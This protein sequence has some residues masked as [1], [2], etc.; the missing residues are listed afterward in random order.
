MIRKRLEYSETL[1]DERYP[2]QD[3]LP[4]D[5]LEPEVVLQTCLQHPI[6]FVIFDL[7]NAILSC[8]DFDAPYLSIH[9]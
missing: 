2:R 4:F 6:N 8:F 7:I 9:Q 3:F 5:S 1:F